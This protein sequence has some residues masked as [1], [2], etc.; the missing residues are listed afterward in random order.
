MS[1]L[2]FREWVSPAVVSYMILELVEFDSKHPDLTQEKSIQFY[3]KMFFFTKPSILSVLTLK[4]LIP[5]ILSVKGEG[6]NPSPLR[7]LLLL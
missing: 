5:E 3:K 1:P 6:G 4:V 7:S 2:L